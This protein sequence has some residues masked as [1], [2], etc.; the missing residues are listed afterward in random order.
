MR[1]VNLDFQ[2][3]LGREIGNAFEGVVEF[4]LLSINECLQVLIN[5]FG[6]D[7]DVESIK[8][9]TDTQIKQLTSEFNDYF[10]VSDITENMV[11]SAFKQGR[12]HWDC[13]DSDFL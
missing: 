13:N 6:E 3:S 7:F 8:N 11:K 12:W 5:K 1:D 9:L 10:E 4:E 2:Q